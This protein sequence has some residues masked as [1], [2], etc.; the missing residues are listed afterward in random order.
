MPKNSDLTLTTTHGTKT[1]RTDTGSA[2]IAA[3]YAA[4]N[5]ATATVTASDGDTTTIT[6][7]R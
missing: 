6:P 1:V 3:V 5:G 4:R 7:S 2:V